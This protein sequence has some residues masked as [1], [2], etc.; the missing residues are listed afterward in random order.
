MLSLKFK[1]NTLIQR[2]GSWWYFNLEPCWSWILT[3]LCK[4]VNYVKTE[5]L[6]I[7]RT[8]HV[9]LNHF[10]LAVFLVNLLFM[11]QFWQKYRQAA[12]LV[13][14]VKYINKNITARGKCRQLDV[15]N[16][17]WCII[18]SFFF[19]VILVSNERLSL[20]SLD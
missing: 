9:C 3:L 18:Y 4:I 16:I 10:R 2:K 5:V 17:T 14:Q 20:I 8:W 7:L 12:V 11:I 6:F 13:C 15:K 1:Y 19:L